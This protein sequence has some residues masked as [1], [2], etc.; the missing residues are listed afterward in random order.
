MS[1]V[2][3]SA[4]LIK[5]RKYKEKDKLLT[6]LTEDFGKVVARCK[7]ARDPLNHWGHNT[8]PPNLCWLQLFERNSFYIVTEMKPIAN[9]FTI[10]EDYQRILAFEAMANLLDILLEPGV[11]LRETFA[12]SL[13]FLKELNS[14][15]S[16]PHY[17]SYLY[18]FL[19]LTKQGY[20]LQMGKCIICSEPFSEANQGYAVSYEEGGIICNQCGKKVSVFNPL[21][22]E[23]CSFL[24]GFE[25][26]S[27]FE[28][29]NQPIDFFHNKEE[30]DRIVREY[31][32]YRFNRKLLTVISLKK[33]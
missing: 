16:D 10:M 25:K 22:T 13:S 17:L 27:D 11:P 6:F 23:F 32:K 29:R 20:P 18:I 21:T 12:L 7:G 31:F 9:L 4:I 19:F 8:E 33:M 24:L 26:I 15:K 28:L 5:A 30:L 14:T 3:T 2:K 1:I